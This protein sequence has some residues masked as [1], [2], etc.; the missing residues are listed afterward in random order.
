MV[1]FEGLKEAEEP[2][3]LPNAAELDT[4]RLHLDIQVLRHGMRKE[5]KTRGM[6][7]STSKVRV[8]QAD[9]SRKDGDTL[10]LSRVQCGM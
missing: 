5:K 6:R 10:G 4:E 7:A 3:G 8:D 2:R 9:K 1:S